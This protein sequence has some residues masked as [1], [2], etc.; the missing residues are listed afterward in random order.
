MPYRTEKESRNLTIITVDRYK[1]QTSGQILIS[2]ITLQCDPYSVTVT[3]VPGGV[4]E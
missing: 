1:E 4:E 2:L 3:G